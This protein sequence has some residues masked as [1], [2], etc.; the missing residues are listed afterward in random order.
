MTSVF[1][2]FA[3]L[4]LAVTS[5]T[6]LTFT[7]S[8]VQATARD[9]SDLRSRELW[10]KKIEYQFILQNDSSARVD[11][12]AFVKN[13]KGQRVNVVILNKAFFKKEAAE[14]FHR[15]EKS[16]SGES[17]LN[18][19]LLGLEKDLLRL[20]HLSDAVPAMDSDLVQTLKE[21]Q[22]NLEAMA[23]TEL[24][25]NSL[26]QGRNPKDAEARFVESFVQARLQ[27][28]EV[29][30]VAHLVDMQE[31]PHQGDAHFEKFSE[32]NAFYSELAFGSHPQDVMAQAIA[33]M[34][35]EMKQGKRVDHSIAKVA[36]VVEFLKSCPKMRKT[37]LKGP[38]P[39][40]CLAAL[41]RIQNSDFVMAGRTLY[42][43]SQKTKG[44]LLAS[45]P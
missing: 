29:H 18:E 8:E 4:L 41:A 25:Q 22:K 36:S 31:N 27:T 17:A 13:V 9:Y 35:D 30:E 39:S 23:W 16:S 19:K 20:Q 40:C 44:I 5:L 6:A 42:Q 1:R 38:L 7:A 32:L 28:I 45:L 33:G 12:E 24:F 2:K 15:L 10:G 21:L 26:A 3:S 11:G 34:I 43:K 14:L 37:F